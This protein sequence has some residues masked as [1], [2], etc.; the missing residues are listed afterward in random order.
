MDVGNPRSRKTINQRPKDMVI[1]P[2][3]RDQVGFAS[4]MYPQ[5]AECRNK[6]YNDEYVSTVEPNVVLHEAAI[7]DVEKQYVYS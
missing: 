6:I 4:L 7:E 3:W 5:D 1:F 2:E